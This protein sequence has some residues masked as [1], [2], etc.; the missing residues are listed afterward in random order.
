MANTAKANQSLKANGTLMNPAGIENDRPPIHRPS[1]NGTGTVPTAGTHP[2]DKLNA[3]QHLAV[4]DQLVSQNGK[5]RLVMQ[6][7][8]N[9][10]LYRT[11]NGQ[12]L[13]ASNTWRKPV[14]T[15]NMQSDGNVVCYDAAGHPYW[16]S[17]TWGHPGSSV[18]LQNDGNL[19][20]YSPTGA[21]LWASNTMTNWNPQTRVQLILKR[22]SCANTTEAGHDEVYYLF[23]GVDGAGK[24]VSHRGPDATQ[25]G[26]AD[27]QMAWDM[28]DSGTVQSRMFNAILCD[29][30]LA[31]GQTATFA[32]GFMESDGQDWASTV[33]GAA[34]VAGKIGAA[35][36]LVL[37]ASQVVGWLGSFIPKN[38][39]DSLGAF[40]L[41]IVNNGGQVVAQEVSTG[42][43]ASLL[44]P[45]DP[46]SGTFTVHF[47]H[48]DGDYV[49][50][51]LIRGI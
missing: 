22:L 5:V 43:F 42:S 28:N 15:A 49:A 32:M 30:A 9:L 31:A 8:G 29:E 38:Q 47:Q 20:V 12:A 13:W 25:S 35:V 3:L 10:V 39:D 11:D 26:D 24:Q 36:P 6:A 4:N 14:V 45:L 37:I 19:V 34:D 27:N 17:G 51:F 41:R 7:D 1:T 2:V 18:T 21:P 46:R 16:S 33:K 23:S 44:H 40:A 50:D 48:D